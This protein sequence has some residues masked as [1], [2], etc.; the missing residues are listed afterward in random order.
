MKTSCQLRHSRPSISSLPCSALG[1]LSSQQPSSFSTLLLCPRGT[2]LYHSHRPINLAP[3][4]SCSPNQLLLRSMS[5][6]QARRTFSYLCYLSNCS[7]C[8]VSARRRRHR[9]LWLG[10][11]VTSPITLL[12]PWSRASCLMFTTRRRSSTP[13]ASWTF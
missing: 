4:T 9:C 13:S 8:T 10:L 5:R 2:R 6:A 3:L 11:V 1:S 7:P 12:Y